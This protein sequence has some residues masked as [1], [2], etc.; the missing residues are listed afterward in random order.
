VL[1]VAG[2]ALASP[3]EYVSAGRKPLSPRPAWMDELAP[4]RRGVLQL[5]AEGSST[6]QIAAELHYSEQNVGYHLGQL[7]EKMLVRN[8]AVLVARA[9]QHGLVELPH[10]G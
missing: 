4:T 8:R 2:T 7:R 9:V 6:R 10:E 1:G 5:A 3:D